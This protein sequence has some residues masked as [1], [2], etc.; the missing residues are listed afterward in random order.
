MLVIDKMVPR[1]QRF[2]E[3]YRKHLEQ[4]GEF[5]LLILH[6]FDQPAVIGVN[7]LIHH[8]NSDAAFF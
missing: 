8:E 5:S 7:K 4:V 3:D 1:H 6:H 2:L